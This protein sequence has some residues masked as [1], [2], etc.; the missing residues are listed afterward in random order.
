[1]FNQRET[2]ARGVIVHELTH[3]WS[4]KAGQRPA[5]GIIQATGS[6]YSE[7]DGRYIPGEPQSIVSKDTYGDHHEDFAEAVA[8]SIYPDYEDAVANSFAGSKRNH[9]ATQTMHCYGPG[10]G[11]G[12]CAGR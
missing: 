12:A 11:S 9:Y 6:R 3:R 2:L 10:R 8:A 7:Y 5:D 4:D 1:V